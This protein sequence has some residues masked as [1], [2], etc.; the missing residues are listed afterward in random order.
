M[1]AKRLTI[2]VAAGELIDKIAILEIKGERIQ[3]PK[4]RRNV[5]IEYEA[6]KSAR[7]V[8]IEASPDLSRHAAD[9]KTVNEELWDLE[10]RIRA[11][12]NE[13]KFG[14]DFVELARAIYITNDRRASIKR[15]IN[16]LLG[17]RIVEEKSYEEY[18]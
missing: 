15:A 6:L 7:D 16:D 8:A 17:S 5:Q 4:K 3:D 2:E 1:S 14:R 10:D 9:L 12:E 18:A 11:C 13:K